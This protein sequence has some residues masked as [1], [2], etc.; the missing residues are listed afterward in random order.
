MLFDPEEH[1]PVKIPQ[2][3]IERIRKIEGKPTP[4]KDNE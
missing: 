2:E 4:E 1:L 3:V